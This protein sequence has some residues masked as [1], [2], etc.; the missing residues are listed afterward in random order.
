MKTTTFIS[1]LAAALLCSVAVA[2]DLVNSV[3]QLPSKTTEEKLKKAVLAWAV[4]DADLEEAAGRKAFAD[5]VRADVKTAIA[6]PFARAKAAPANL[7]PPIA[8]PATN[9]Y[10]I[11]AMKR[12]KKLAASTEAYPKGPAGAIVKDARGWHFPTI[13][14]EALALTRALCHPQSAMA[15]DPSL[16]APM[17]RRFA[18]VYEYLTPGSKQL[19]D[20]GDSSELAEMYLLVRSVY[21][22]LILPTYKQAWEKGISVNSDAIVKQ[23]GEVFIAA[24]PGTAYPNGHIRYLSALMFGGLVLDR[25]ELRRIAD[26]GL[27][28]QNTGLYEDGGFTYIGLQNEVLTYHGVNVLHI[29]RYAQVTGDS[30]AKQMVARTRWYYPLSVEPPGVVEYST[31]ASW[32]HYWNQVTGGAEAY[33][34]AGATD[35]GHNLRI[36]Q[37][38]FSSPD[39][40]YAT[41][42]RPELK[43]APAPDQYVVFDRNVLGARGRFGTFSFS[44]TSRDY[45]D[46]NRGKSS[47]VGCMVLNSNEPKPESWPLNAALQDA[48][49]EVRIKPGDGGLDRSKTHLWLA[50]DETNAAI[51]SEHFGSVSTRYRLSAYKTKSFDWAGRQVW[52][53]TPQRLVGLVEIESLKDQ[54]ALGVNGVLQFISGRE[55]WGTRKEF[56]SISANTISYGKLTTTI[57]Q[58]DFAEIR[59][60]YTD[61]FAGDAK[62]AGRL[63]LLDSTQAS[64]GSGTYK[65]GAKHFYLAEVRPDSSAVA[66]DIKRLDL[67]NGLL[68]FDVRE[69]THWYRILFNPTSKDVAAEQS[70]EAFGRPIYLH[71]SGETYRP[72]WISESGKAEATGRAMPLVL[73]GGRATVRVP[74]DAHVILTDLP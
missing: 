4:A 27:K 35:C 50:Q 45:G 28:L 19:V 38:N 73:T 1:S 68:G 33:I 29:A 58:H 47:V 3:N 63:L 25:P 42:Y 71:R 37:T 46:D 49:V 9:P 54:Q 30:L 21:P 60:E 61:T 41:F 52:L 13:T 32:K 23:Y 62:K 6:Q 59:T 56:Q 69:G 2:D 8:Q 10:A 40:I 72:A 14:G 22:D 51:A 7:F 26:S 70:L 67:P 43:P 44:S 55:R 31:A 24:Q 57:Y 11:E 20:F 16:V 66:S 17:L 34:V 15:G 48:A 53:L 12:A 36:A 65:A 64:G 74:A 18:H 5:R 39:L